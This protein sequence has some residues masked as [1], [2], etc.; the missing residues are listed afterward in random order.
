MLADA[1]AA[2]RRKRATTPAPARPDRERIQPVRKTARVEPYGPADFG[3]RP[4]APRLAVAKPFETEPPP[5]PE[6]RGVPLGRASRRAVE[7]LSNAPMAANGDVPDNF[8]F[9]PQDGV[10]AGFYNGAGDIF[11]VGT[12]ALH[13]VCCQEI[14]P[15]EGNGKVHSAPLESK[16]LESNPSPLNCLNL[17]ASHVCCP[18]CFRAGRPRPGGIPDAL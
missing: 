17:L 2:V 14:A 10:G 9:G 8:N 11:R 18:R 5:P 13:F 1:A 4:A 6:V 15:T 7:A 12:G 3:V 16:P